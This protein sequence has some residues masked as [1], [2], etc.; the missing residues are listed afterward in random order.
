MATKTTKTT[1][2]TVKVDMDAALR[3]IK[4]HFKAA[5]SAALVAPDTSM[6]E[7]EDGRYVARLMSATLGK[8]QASGRLQVDFAWKF[9]EPPYAGKMKHAY[10]GMETEENQKYVYADLRKLGFDLTELDATD[11]P[12]LLEQITATKPHLL[13]QIALKTK[14]DY[15]NVFINAL[16]EDDEDGEE[17]ETHEDEE[18]ADAPK[19]TVKKSAKKAE[20]EEDEDD[21][22]EDDEDEDGT[23]DVEEEAEDEPTPATVKKTAKKTAKKPEPEPEEDEEDEDEEDEEEEADEDEQLHISVGSEVMVQTKEGEVQGTIVEIFPDEE[24]IRVKTAAGKMLRL[25]AD[26]VVSVVEKT[27]VAAKKAKKR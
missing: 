18:K 13:C 12:D 6:T 22:D 11:V 4:K 19:K 8:S 15:Q 2:A 24:K 17:A 27:V 10:Q 25:P 3:T 26:R 1:T 5:K 9:V 21:E 23:D 16:L 14:N 20:P 7:F